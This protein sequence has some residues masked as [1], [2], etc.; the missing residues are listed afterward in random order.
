MRSPAI[1]SES[2]LK[3]ITFKRDNQIDAASISDRTL[4]VQPVCSQSSDLSLLCRARLRVE[5]KVISSGSSGDLEEL[6]ARQPAGGMQG[7]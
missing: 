3:L 5:R 6:L 1:S 7:G 2:Q 4:S